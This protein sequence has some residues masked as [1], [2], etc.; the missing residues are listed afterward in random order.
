MD[1]QFQ[2]DTPTNPQHPA[3]PQHFAN[4][5]AHLL[6][7]D[8]DLDPLFLEESW[9]LGI[10]A[11]TVRW[12]QRQRTSLERER[13]SQ[14]FRS[15]H[16]LGSIF[17]VD[18]G[19]SADFIPQALAAAVQRG[20]GPDS[21]QPPAQPTAQPTAAPTPHRPGAPSLAARG[22][23]R[24]DSARRGGK[25][26]GTQND[27]NPTPNHLM[28]T[29]VQMTPRHAC[30]LLGVA[31]NSTHDQLKSAYRR[32]VSQWHPDRLGPATDDARQRA[33]DQMA[34][35]NEAYRLLRTLPQSA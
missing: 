3:N 4:Q 34:A 1:G 22:P 32:M 13:Q 6:G 10:P 17:F 5:I 23:Q 16:N 2:V 30:R 8:S 11:A 28:G 21:L 35:I 25:K 20:Y 31:A 33:T 9:T 7:E 27:R 24:A 18:A 15:L 14:S 29:H 26:G 19:D 12:Q